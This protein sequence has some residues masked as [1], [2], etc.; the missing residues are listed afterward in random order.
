MT[1]TETALE[2]S[3]PTRRASAPPPNRPSQ[4][5][6]TAHWLRDFIRRSPMSAFW[7]GVVIVIVLVAVF[8]DVLFREGAAAR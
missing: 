6:R 4:L 5:A 2:T 7:G 3:N 1:S 8:A